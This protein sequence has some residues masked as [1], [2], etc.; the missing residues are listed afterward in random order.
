[1]LVLLC[2]STST[3]VYSTSVVMYNSTISDYNSKNRAYF[4]SV[5]IRHTSVPCLRRSN[6]DEFF[7]SIMTR[8]SFSDFVQKQPATVISG[9]PD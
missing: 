9:K 5:R 4:V 3:T 8:K 2:R 6:S 7:V 1:M